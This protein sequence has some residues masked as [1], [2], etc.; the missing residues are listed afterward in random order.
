[1]AQAQPSR[2]TITLE[3]FF[4]ATADEV[5]ELW[6]TADGVQAWWG[7]EGFEVKVR[8]MDL[9]P[10]GEMTYVMT[11]TAPDQID[12]MRKA[13]MPLA[14]EAHL[15]F[16]E[17]DPPRRLAY[18]HRADFIP[19]VEP[20]IVATAVDIEAAGNGVRM[21]LTIEAMHDAEWTQRMVSGWESELD[22]LAK[23]IVAARYD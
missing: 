19:G 10:G 13:G 15:T 3:R 12:F 6:T 2:S 23:V 5:W 21:A 8:E 7:P 1:M 14:T 22:K 4:D 9:R 18:N 17:V 20:Y 11:A 16:S